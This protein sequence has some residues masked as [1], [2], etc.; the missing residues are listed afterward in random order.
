MKPN[1]TMPLARQKPPEPADPN[2]KLPGRQALDFLTKGPPEQQRIMQFGRLTPIGAGSPTFGAQPRPPK[3]D[4][5][6]N[7]G[8]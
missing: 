5:R 7:G 1:K 6:K 8:F 2:A 3:S 4:P